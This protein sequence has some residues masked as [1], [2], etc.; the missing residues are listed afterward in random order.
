M[1]IGLRCTNLCRG[2]SKLGSSY[3]FACGSRFKKSLFGFNNAHELLV[4]GGN[5]PLHEDA[6]NPAKMT[7]DYRGYSTSRRLLNITEAYSCDKSNCRP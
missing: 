5:V 3:G 1:E 4:V 7:K 2:Y 6:Y